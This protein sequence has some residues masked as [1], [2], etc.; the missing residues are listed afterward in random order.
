MEA[1]S[2]D[3]DE[4]SDKDFDYLMGMPMWSL[5]QEKKDDLCR[6]RWNKHF[7]CDESYGIWYTFICLNILT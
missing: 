4:D 5:T 3:E 1:A 6:E 2:D 7:C